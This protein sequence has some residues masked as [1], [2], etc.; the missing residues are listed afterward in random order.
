MSETKW[1]IIGFIVLVLFFVFCLMLPWIDKKVLGATMMS[2]A[3]VNYVR[4][5]GND[6]L[7]SQM[8]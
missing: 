1:N 7:L 4:G 2:L 5:P 6:F 8:G 3:M